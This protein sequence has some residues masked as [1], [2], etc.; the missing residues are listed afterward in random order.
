MK[1]DHT[2]WKITAFK[3]GKESVLNIKVLPHVIPSL[4]PSFR[5]ALIQIGG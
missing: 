4:I 5:Q 2:E 3:V 1:F